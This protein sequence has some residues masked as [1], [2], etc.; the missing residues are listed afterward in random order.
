MGTMVTADVRCV[1]SDVFA[2]R[3]LN[4]GSGMEAETAQLRFPVQQQ[5]FYNNERSRGENVGGVAALKFL[6]RR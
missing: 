3:P 5:L 6:A 2:R 1:R 4:F